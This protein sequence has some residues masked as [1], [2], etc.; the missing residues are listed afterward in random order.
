MF[1]QFCLKSLPVVAKEFV[2]IPDLQPDR[3]HLYSAEFLPDE[4]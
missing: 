1:K 2:K 4:V 3:L